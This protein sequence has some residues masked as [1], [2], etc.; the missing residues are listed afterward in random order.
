MSNAALNAWFADHWSLQLQLIGITLLAVAGA[1][2]VHYEG[3]RQI[4]LRV[5][6]S[7]RRASHHLMLYASYMVVLLHL[8]EILIFAAAFH[9][10]KQIPGMGYLHDAHPHFYDSFYFSAMVF[11][12]I[13][14][15]DLYP[16]GP[17][18]LLTGIEGLV[19]L[20]LIGWSVSFTY[21]EMQTFW[22]HDTDRSNTPGTD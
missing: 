14:L 2:L 20:L 11:S 12:S 10:L 9:Y 6:R 17:I 19:G 15:G 22:P 13:G 4:N 3:L 5:I 1:I 18:R 7:R 21:W 16:I 8:V